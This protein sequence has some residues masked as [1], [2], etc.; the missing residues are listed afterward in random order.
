MPYFAWKGIDL[1]GHTRQ[2]TSFARTATLLQASLLREEIAL[3][4]HRRPL[5]KRL[6]PLSRRVKGELCD[7]LS[8]LLEAG[9]RLADALDIA[10]KTLSCC[11][12][13]GIVIDC[14]A[15]VREGIPLS[16]ILEKHILLVDPLLVALVAAGQES[17][18][19]G[20][21]LKTLS[22]HYSMHE[23]L[24]Q[25]LKSA[26]AMPAIT[27][28]FFC[29]SAYA[30][31]IAVIPRFESLFAMVKGPLPQSTQ[32]LF[33]MSAFVRQ[34]SSVIWLGV[35][36]FVIV[37][38]KKLFKG[39]RFN[40]FKIPGLKKLVTIY[41]LTLFLQSLSILLEGGVHLSKAL[42]FASVSVDHDEISMALKVMRK[43]VEAGLPLSDAFTQSGLL[44]SQ[45]AEMLCRLGEATGVLPRMVHKAA[46]LYERRLYKI[47]TVITTCIPP[48]ILILLGIIIGFLIVAVYTPLLTFAQSIG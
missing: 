10:G 17:G 12:A 25:K 20:K 4:S 1:A 5:F 11:L 38:A 2:G 39:V 36:F 32:I 31:F 14:A 18:A 13:R 6:K 3:L 21:V 19:L 29:I 28:C 35:A 23:E 47:L 16:D 9:I 22:R 15:S 42:C 26:L 34:S 46:D 33:A 44:V 27:F 48:F 40:G 30:L 43:K 41:Y 24:V 7:H 8:N 45:E 37:L